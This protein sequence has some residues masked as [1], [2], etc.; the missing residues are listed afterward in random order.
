MTE[1][2]AQAIQGQGDKGFRDAIMDREAE[3]LSRM[4][5]EERRD[6]AEMHRDLTA[7]VMSRPSIDAKLLEWLRAHDPASGYEVRRIRLQVSP[8]EYQRASESVRKTYDKANL[9]KGEA[10]GGLYRER[11]VVLVRAPQVEAA[12]NCKPVFRVATMLE[13]PEGGYIEPTKGTLQRYVVD[14]V[15]RVK[16]GGAQKALMEQAAAMRREIVEEERAKREKERMEFYANAEALGLLG[17]GPGKIPA[18]L[19]DG[20]AHRAKGNLIVVA[21]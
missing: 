16:Y 4:S 3:S 2:T 11:W 18:P 14:T 12:L 7:I 8:A 20:S 13:T 15:E 6:I 9:E 17:R 21:R 19:G 1:S 10:L 5:D